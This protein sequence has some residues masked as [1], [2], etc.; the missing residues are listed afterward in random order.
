MLR[1]EVDCEGE[2]LQAMLQAAHLPTIPRRKRRSHTRSAGVQQGR[3]LHRPA[4]GQPAV[5]DALERLAGRAAVQPALHGALVRPE[6]VLRGAGL[7]YDLHALEHRCAPAVHGCA[8]AA[9]GRSISSGHC[10]MVRTA[11]CPMLRNRCALPECSTSLAYVTFFPSLNSQPTH[12]PSCGTILA[13]RI[14]WCHAGV[15]D[16]YFETTIEQSFGRLSFAPVINDNTAPF[17]LR[18]K[19]TSFPFHHDQT[20]AYLQ[21]SLG[22]S[23]DGSEYFLM[24]V[25]APLYQSISPSVCFLV[26]RARVAKCATACPA[27]Q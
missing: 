6:P 3:L 27:A 26:L 15:Y 4:V 7:L 11:W 22:I 16:R 19:G 5:P 17:L 24:H 2:T 10:G 21:D 25:H 13:D 18:N 9:A 1:D 23:T 14:I 8:T 12:N 20:I